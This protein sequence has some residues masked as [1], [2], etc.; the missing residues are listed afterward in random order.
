V[1][2]I[3]RHWRA[4]LAFG[5]A[6]AALAFCYRA[7]WALAAAAGAYAVLPAVLRVRGALAD[8]RAI[9]GMLQ[10]PGNSRPAS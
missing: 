9:M 6:G 4:W 2:L 3:V 7:D 5:A 10:R 8:K 1:L